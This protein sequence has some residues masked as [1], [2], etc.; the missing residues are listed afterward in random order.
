MQR[1]MQQRHFSFLTRLCFTPVKRGIY[2]RQLQLRHQRAD[3]RRVAL[4]LP[5]SKI[6]QGLAPCLALMLVHVCPAC[7]SSFLFLS[8]LFLRQRI[9]GCHAH[10]G[11]IALR[12]HLRQHLRKSAILFHRPHLRSKCL[13]VKIQQWIAA[14]HPA[15]PHIAHVAQADG[16]ALCAQLEQKAADA[17]MQFLGID[18]FRNDPFQ[19]VKDQ[20][21][22]LIAVAGIHATGDDHEIWLGQLIDHR[23]LDILSQPAVDHGFLQRRRIASGQQVT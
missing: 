1:M 10:A 13:V 4:R 8:G 20:R 14:V 17:R 19:R 16:I 21:M 15:L 3:F 18:P 6:A 22:Q 11:V 5:S 12:Q 23:H 2:I 7:T 9:R